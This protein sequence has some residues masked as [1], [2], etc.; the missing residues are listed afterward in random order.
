[1][2]D[3]SKNFPADAILNPENYNVKFEINTLKPYNNNIIR[4]NLGLQSETND[5]YYWQPPYDSQGNWET[6]V[7][8]LDEIF[9]AYE[10]VGVT[11]S[12]NPN[13]YWTRVMIFD[14]NELDCDIAFDNFR[15]VPKILN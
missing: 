9:R 11:P 5:A 13:G 6:V 15:V 1:M 12:V 4:L 7:I 10:D 3:I 8:P 2:G 14:G